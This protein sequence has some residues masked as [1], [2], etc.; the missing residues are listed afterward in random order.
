[1]RNE[2]ELLA[3]AGGKESLIAAIQNGANAVYLGGQSFSAR[4]SANNFSD[5]ELAEA[6]LYAHFRDV[7]IYVTVNTLLDERELERA[8]DYIYYLDTIGVDG[9]IV[10]DLGLAK[11]IRENFPN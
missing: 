7:R 11:V 6:V 1:M 2:I 8:V 10:Q 4:A 5:E 9:I 3:P